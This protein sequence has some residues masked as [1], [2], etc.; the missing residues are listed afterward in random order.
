MCRVCGRHDPRLALLMLNVRREP[1]ACQRSRLGRRRAPFWHVIHHRFH[2]T[3]ADVSPSLSQTTDLT[4]DRQE[5]GQIAPQIGDKQAR[6]PKTCCDPRSTDIFINTEPF[7]Q[8]SSSD[9]AARHAVH[10]GEDVKAIT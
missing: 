1:G 5:D 6:G 4:E 2:L 3:A 7:M 10:K 9:L 8:G